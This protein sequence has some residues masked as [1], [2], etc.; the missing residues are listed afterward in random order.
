MNAEHQTSRPPEPTADAGTPDSSRRGTRTASFW[1]GRGALVI[2]ALILALAVYL[3]VGLLTMDVPESAEAPGPKFYPTLLAVGSYLLAILL[4]IDT[5]RR[6][7]SGA[8]DIAPES[9]EETA[10]A[11]AAAAAAPTDPKAVAISVAAFLVFALVLQP[12]GW[13]L[14]AAALFWVMSMAL[15]AQRRVLSLGIGLVLSSAVQVAFSMGLGL[16]LP[17]GILGGIF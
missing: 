17:A 3:T 1:Q 12:L 4:V 7:Q 10:A 8:P 14:S 13:L 5:M 11:T 16:T 6:T 9:D 15:G 2:A